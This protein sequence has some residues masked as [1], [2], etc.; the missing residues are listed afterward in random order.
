MS[1]SDAPASAP[2]AAAPIAGL[3]SIADPVWRRALFE[4]SFQPAWIY[5]LKTLGFLD[6]NLAQ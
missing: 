6:V 3:P 1:T 5:D 2:A 4:E